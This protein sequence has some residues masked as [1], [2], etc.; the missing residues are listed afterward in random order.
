MQKISPNSQTS[1]RPPTVY[2]QAEP[3][4]ALYVERE[5]NHHRPFGEQTKMFCELTELGAAEGVQVV[6]LCPGY[7]LKRSGWKYNPGQKA[8]HQIDYP[9][10]G[11]VL[12]RSGTFHQA[13]LPQV[14][15]DLLWFQRDGLLH[16]LP[17]LCGNK[18]HLY[19]VLK[20]VDS[21]RTYLPET[22]LANTAADIS[23]FLHK[24]RDIYVKPLNGAQ[25]ISIYRFYLDRQQV[26][27]VWQRRLV[28]RQTE[29]TS[30]QFRPDTVVESVRL[31]DD[32]ALR[33]FCEKFLPRTFLLQKT[34]Q[35]PTTKD[36]HP[37]DFR[38]LVQF[39]PQAEVVARV[40]R[41]GQAGA[42]TTN[43]HT[44]GKGV[45]ASEV[46]SALR[47]TR[48]TVCTQSLDQAALQIAQ[49]LYDKYGPY[50]EVGIDLALGPND[51]VSFFEVNPTP[52]RRM[53]RSIRGNV[54]E[55]SLAYLIEYAK[56]ASGPVRK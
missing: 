48:G 10:P 35:L 41:V 52:G 3:S 49:T 12:R 46:L 47:G 8:W 25:G 56:N 15:R 43:I 51:D 2:K 34:V 44:G 53:L 11:V 55:L 6:V 28:P 50:A 36:G 23:E 9:R 14:T 21:L 39:H 19:Q 54:R 24:W 33:Q 45:D 29:R 31:R 5:Q 17:R 26:I 4:L 37:F 1:R 38:W 13:S 7:L 42:V 16:S 40:A 32:R 27:A 30:N 22:A 20:T 18:W